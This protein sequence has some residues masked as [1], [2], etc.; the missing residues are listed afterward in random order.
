MRAC[1]A[2]L[3]LD[4]QLAQ[5]VQIRRAVRVETV[6]AHHRWVY[7][8][9]HR[10]EQTQRL[11]VVVAGPAACP[12]P[13]VARFGLVPHCP[14][15]V[16]DLRFEVETPRPRALQPLTAADRAGGYVAVL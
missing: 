9:G 3:A 15:D 7:H 5:P 4:R 10:D 12:D 14:P 6:A 16:L 1:P 8:R 13:A 2:Q 11:A